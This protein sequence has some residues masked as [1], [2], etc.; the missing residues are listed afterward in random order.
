MNLLENNRPIMVK[1]EKRWLFITPNGSLNIYRK[2]IL[3]VADDVP[4]EPVG[5]GLVMNPIKI[6]L[7]INIQ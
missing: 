1:R 7:R 2:F 4:K 3:K 5:T 6:N